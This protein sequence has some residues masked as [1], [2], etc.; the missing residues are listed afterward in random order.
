MPLL[1][2]ELASLDPAA[3]VASVDELAVAYRG[4][5]N[6]QNT[7]AST[8]NPDRQHTSDGL[9]VLAR[10]ALE[11][12]QGGARLLQ[13]DPQVLTAFRLANQ[14]MAMAAR[15]QRPHEA[16]AWRLFQLAFLLLNLEGLADPAHPDR[17]TVDLLFFPTGGGKTEAY[18]GVAATAMLLRRLRHRDDAHQGAGVTVLLRYTLRLLTLDQLGRAATLTCALEQ[19]RLADPT[20]LGE[21]RFAVGLWVGRKAT[22]NRMEDAAK[23][24][25][26]YHR[27][28]RDPRN[29]PPLPLVGCPW[30][31]AAFTANSFHI[32]AEGRT[33][34]ALRV[35]CDDV[36][37]AYSFAT[38]PQG[39]P[40]VVVDEQLYRELPPFLIATV[41][42]FALLP[43]RGEVG[44]L[45]GKVTHQDDHGFYT[46]AQS[47]PKAAS[48]LPGGLPPPALVIQD[49]LHLI[50]G[51]LGTM[52]G[53][54]ETGLEALSR[55]PLGAG[56]KIVASTATA[57]RAAEQIRAI[58]GREAHA[59]FP[60]QGV[61][62]G[63]TWFATTAT[64]DEQARLYVGVAAPGRSSKAILARVATALLSA[65]Q[66]LHQ[67]DPAS[68]DTYMTLTCY[69]NALRELGG[70]QR[71]F[72]EEISPR[73]NL[74]AR[75]HPQDRKDSQWFANRRLSY[76]LLELTSRQDTAAIRDT[77][78]R[79]ERPYDA[80]SNRADVLLASSMIS[81]G[82]DIPR[83]GLMVVNGQPR[84]VA[85]YIQASSRVGR[86][87][88]GLVVTCYNLFKPRDRSH[89]ER[90]TAFHE[91]FYRFVEASS[92]TPFSG[93]ALDRGLAGLTVGM[94]RH[95]TPGLTPASGAERIAKA[96]D[97]EATVTR[98]IQER[99]GH[100]RADAH[101]DLP[102]Q[103]GKKVAEIF[104]AW[105]AVAEAKAK[106]AG[107][108]S[109]SSWEGRKGAAS[110]LSM[111]VDAVP[112][113][114]EP[115]RAPTSMRDVEQPVH[116]WV[117]K[118]RATEAE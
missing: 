27:N 79:L 13:T 92:V 49:E 107:A 25:R 90:F 103:V 37:C 86:A 116:I 65:A 22:A 117:N 43:W 17:A 77:K 101:P 71:L 48:R 83:L 70:A 115:F 3:L 8:L 113:A 95:L 10:D 100:H 89:Y 108:L 33:P 46:E 35:G 69:F 87:T 80:R 82:V 93:R 15:R 29:A 31:G 98:L 59:L 36:G 97:V 63:D 96:K 26:D 99:A 16:P 78:G 85:E 68:A 62:D 111:S 114:F 2:E 57:R 58:F 32:H 11:R 24:V 42:K 102:N 105:R 34:M 55:G 67:L 109:Y 88:P 38:N 60:P 6:A 56:P 94:A 44:A 45:F 51:P 50:T 76:D 30:C 54:Y 39:I 18:L 112:E 84:T 75:R 110:L 81:V 5:I 21:K 74:M 28:S 41:D 20:L 12:I 4:W 9:M 64:G 23:Q 73:A 19:L 52:V 14:A 40:V 91:S 1:M 47:P 72:Q 61:D 106:E 53:L 66:H 7:A 104:S 118:H